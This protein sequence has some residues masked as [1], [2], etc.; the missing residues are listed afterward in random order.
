MTGSDAARRRAWTMSRFRYGE[1]AMRFDVAIRPAAIT[2]VMGPSGSG[3][4]TLLNLIAGFE[5]PASGRDP[6]RRRGR[7]RACRRPTGRS[8]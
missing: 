5:T 4:S 3:K 1:T 8:R 6:D 7:D 2:A